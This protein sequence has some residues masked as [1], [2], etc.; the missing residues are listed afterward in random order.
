MK[1]LP[2]VVGEGIFPGQ[3]QPFSPPDATK[4]IGK[5]HLHADSPRRPSLAQIA[6]PTRKFLLLS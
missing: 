4:L 1:P 5:T 2:Q 6:Y 3:H